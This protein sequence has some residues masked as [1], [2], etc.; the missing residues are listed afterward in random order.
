MNYI[1]VFGL[2]L[3]GLVLLVVGAEILVR[4]ASRLAGSLGISPLVIGLTIV[5]YGTSSPEMA[6]AIQSSLA[7]QVL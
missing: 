5:S 4:G 3:A 1:L 7:N 6:V 2:L